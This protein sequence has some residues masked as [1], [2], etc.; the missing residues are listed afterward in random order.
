MTRVLPVGLRLRYD[1]QPKRYR[2]TGEYSEIVGKVQYRVLSKKSLQH[3]SL[4]RAIA[5]SW[6][7]KKL[8]ERQNLIGLVSLSKGSFNGLLKN[9]TK[10]YWFI[11]YLVLYLQ[12]H[13]TWS[14][15]AV[16]QSGNP[17]GT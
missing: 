10:D 17:P 6:Q 2:S 5:D 11:Y 7:L 13:R 8:S 14:P 16:H 12:S 1:Y 15:S 4:G 9:Q 3:K